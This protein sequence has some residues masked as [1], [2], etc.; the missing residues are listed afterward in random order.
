MSLSRKAG[1]SIPTHPLSTADFIHR[2]PP[3]ILRILVS[4]APVIK[5]THAFL[6]LATWSTPYPHHSLLLVVGYALA[7]IAGYPV[8]RYAPQLLILAYLGYAWIATLRPWA[9]S[10]ASAVGRIRETDGAKLNALVAQL[11][12][13]ADFVSALHRQLLAPVL[14]LLSWSEDPTRTKRLVIF[15]L[16]TYPIYLACYFPW[17][18]LGL[19]TLQLD[20][21]LPWDSIGSAQSSIH[22]R[23]LGLLR[24]GSASAL[25]K[26]PPGLEA[27]LLKLSSHP[28]LTL[29]KSCQSRVPVKSPRLVH[30][31]AVRYV[32]ASIQILPPFPLGSLSVRSTVLTVGLRG[33]SKLGVHGCLHLLRVG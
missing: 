24:T 19:P 10:N 6:L 32:A 21:L 5:T 17:A 26:A 33:S 18:S 8:L 13:I 28:H 29:P 16:T 11:D 15:L 7:V 3:A 14:G 27:Q 25:A 30:S 4:F 23:A 12:D 1:G 9:R 2:L 20:V 31:R 22:S